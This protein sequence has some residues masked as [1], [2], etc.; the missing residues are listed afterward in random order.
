MA[1]NIAESPPELPEHPVVSPKF[2][3]RNF[4]AFRYTTKLRA[5]AVRRV[6]Q[7]YANA[8]VLP[9][10]GRSF[11]AGLALYQARPDKKYSLAD[12]VSMQAMRTEG[13]TEILTH[14]GDFRQE[15]FTLL[16]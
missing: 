15:G 5:I 9:Q 14:D 2:V 10:S 3:I 4:T 7:I 8:M 11:Q 16:L 6:N 13:I 1:L 12:C